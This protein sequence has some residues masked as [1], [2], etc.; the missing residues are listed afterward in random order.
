[1]ATNKMAKY[2][3]CD[4]K[5]RRWYLVTIRRVCVLT[6]KMAKQQIEI[7]RYRRSKGVKGTADSIAKCRKLIH[8]ADLILKEIDK[9]LAGN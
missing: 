1:M 6:K 8:E 4:K 2:L 7:N 3:S 5:E 9:A